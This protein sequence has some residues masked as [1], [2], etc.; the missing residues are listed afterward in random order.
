M[1]LDSSGYR[2]E[3]GRGRSPPSRESPT[4]TAP[5]ASPVDARSVHQ[6][7]GDELRGP[8]VTRVLE[9]PLGRTNLR[10]ALAENHGDPVGDPVGLV[11]D[12]GGDADADAAVTGLA[13]CLLGERRVPRVEIRSRL[14]EEGILGVV[15][16]RP[17]EGD[18]GR[19]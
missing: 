9:H 13:D 3:R 10:D 19:T 6:F 16:L 7:A 11:H 4:R 14:I 12:V 17:L 2:F 15:R 5:S 18:F 1:F 8:F